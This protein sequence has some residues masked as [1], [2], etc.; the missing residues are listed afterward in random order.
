MTRFAPS[1]KDGRVWIPRPI[2]AF[3]E[4]PVTPRPLAWFRIGLAAVLIVQAFSQI[5]HLEDLYGRHGIVGWSVMAERSVAGAP[6][7]AWL[8]DGLQA[9]GLPAGCAVPL[10]FA[11]YVGG[12]LGLLLGYRTRLAAVVVWVTHTALMISGEM[13]IYGVDR[14]AQFGLFYCVWLPVGHALSL[15]ESAGRTT[16]GPSFAARFG[17]RLLQLH[18]CVV[19][20]SSGVEK[21]LGEQWWNGEAIWRAVMS[22]PGGLIDGSFLAGVPWLARVLCWMT[23]LLEAGSVAFIWHPRARKFWLAGIVGMHL[24]IALAMNLWIFSATM[25]V[26][27]VAAF[28]VQPDAGIA[29]DADVTTDAVPNRCANDSSRNADCPERKRQPQLVQT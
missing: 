17:L 21:T 1:S 16:S 28:G 6:R 12:L 2:R 4:A 18:L 27:D 25:I 10:A 3:W 11:V 20:V 13:S 19:Y 29:A 24:G 8:D 5:G 9:L 22:M 23:L 7:L 26:F 15:D 14:F